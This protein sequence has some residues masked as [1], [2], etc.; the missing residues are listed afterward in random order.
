MISDQENIIEF[1]SVS[2][3]YDSEHQVIKDLTF[4]APPG[5]FISI[6]GKSGMG[7]T[8]LLK[9]FAGLIQPEYGEIAGLSRVANTGELKIGL[10]SQNYAASLLP[11]FNVSKNIALSLH[12]SELNSREIRLKVA[13]V[14]R[15]VGLENSSEKYPWELS[16]GMQQRV[17][18]ARAII[19]DPDLLLLDEPFASLDIFI[20]SELE[21]LL[22]DLISSTN[23]TTIMVTHDLDEAIYMSDCILSINSKPISEFKVHNVTLPRPRNQIATRL[24]KEFQLL[25]SDL[26]LEMEK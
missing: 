7:K 11:W 23:M 5:Q 16:G 9:L 8:T 13:E 2:F 22:M 25:R 4:V 12:N 26:F 17:A 21:D 15:K 14:L 20:K 3:S 6:C 18:I 1:K 10:V 19:N 24:M